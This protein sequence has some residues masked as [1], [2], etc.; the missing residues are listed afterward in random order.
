MA[1]EN[2]T[3]STVSITALGGST[4]VAGT[5][6]LIITPD[7]DF[8]V[9]ASMCSVGNAM[10]TFSG[11]N[12]WNTVGANVTTGITQVQFVDVGD[13]TVEAIITHGA[14]SINSSTDDFFI[15]I[16]VTASPPRAYSCIR[17]NTSH[18]TNEDGISMSS[19]THL[20]VS[21]MTETEIATGSQHIVS[22]SGEVS[23]TPENVTLIG[24]MRFT[25]TAGFNFATY[26]SGLPCSFNYSYAMNV[27][28]DFWQV[29]VSNYTYD[30]DYV[31]GFDVNVYYATPAIA[32]EGIESAAAFCDLN[33]QLD[34][35]TKP[36]AIPTARA[37]SYSIDGITVENV[38]GYD[39]GPRAVS[40]QGEPGSRFEFFVENEDGEIYDFVSGTFSSEVK[41]REVNYF[42]IPKSGRWTKLVNYPS[43]YSAAKSYNYFV[44]GVYTPAKAS[45]GGEA[46]V[47]K[48]LIDA[49]TTSLG[50][51]VPSRSS[52]TSRVSK[53]RQTVLLKVTQSASEHTI[54]SASSTGVSLYGLVNEVPKK[55]VNIKDP[56]IPYTEA[57]YSISKID[58]SF[59]VTLGGGKAWAATGSI[60][61]GAT[62]YYAPDTNT[63]T[64]PEYRLLNGSIT[65]TYSAGASAT[66]AGTLYVDSFGEVNGD[67]VY[68][69]E[70]YLDNFVKAA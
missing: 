20:D 11:S 61:D 42:E 4:L 55:V 41:R 50:S 10:E 45:V 2:C 68:Q 22:S 49:S 12:I 40:A 14:I 15:D 1:V 63:V 6:T 36:Q 21:G 13:G 69:L 29:T 24:T 19:S 57:P 59:S 39:A 27:M 51:G 43:S 34:I 47:S 33:H 17:M 56:D 18:S 37:R 66:F 58:F 38:V 64:A 48:N 46:G 5:K 53:P 44:E 23:S 67:G 8:Y 62:L 16:D 9:S 52:K 26:P 54:P 31:T 25:A 7:A 28:A 65:S 30:G 32:I 60:L 35:R 3:I 70:I